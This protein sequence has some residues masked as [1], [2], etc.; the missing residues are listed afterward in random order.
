VFT[1]DEM[2]PVFEAA[3]DLPHRLA[4]MQGS[5]NHASTTEEADD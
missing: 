5:A 2:L 1:D 3:L 4:P